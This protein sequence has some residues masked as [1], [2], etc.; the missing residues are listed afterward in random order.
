[1][2]K[3]VILRTLKRPRIMPYGFNIDPAA[4]RMC[5]LWCIEEFGHFD[6]EGNGRWTHR[7]SHHRFYGRGRQSNEA[8]SIYFKSA[9][10]A[11]AFKLR[12]V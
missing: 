1:M 2:I 5:M 11:T 6:I 7:H 3:S 9:V 8:A 12:W 4:Y 10:D